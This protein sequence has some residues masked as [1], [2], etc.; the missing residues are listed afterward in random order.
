MKRL[1]WGLLIVML[2]AGQVQAADGWQKSEPTT[3]R[4]VSDL[5][6]YQAQNNAA[7][8]LMFSNYRENADITYLS[9]ATLTVGTGGI[10]ASNSGGTIRLMVRNTAALT[11]TWSNIDIGSE[12]TSTT[13]YIW[14]KITNITDTTFTGVISTSSTL[15][16][17]SGLTYGRR[18]GSFYNDASGN[19]TLINNDDNLNEIG[20]KTAKSS[21]VTYQALTDGFVS[22]TSLNSGSANIKT[23]GVNPPTTIMAYTDAIASLNSALFFIKKGDYYLVTVSAGTYT[24]YWTPFQ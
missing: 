15:S 8:D 9:A 3:A 11:L 4:A 23:D 22:M 21:G 1:F 17:V 7:I 6:A 16:G 18:L 14:G 2:L 13:Y 10:M 5:S 12:A 19:I 24:V 20:E